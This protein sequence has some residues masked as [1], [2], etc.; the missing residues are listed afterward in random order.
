MVYYRLTPSYLERKNSSLVFMVD[1]LIRQNQN[2]QSGFFLYEYDEL[3]RTLKQL[4]EISR[5][6]F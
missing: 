5:R 4:E 1:A 3:Y 2:S 6:L